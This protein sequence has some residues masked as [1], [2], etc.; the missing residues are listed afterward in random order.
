MSGCFNK[1]FGVFMCLC[2]L[3]REF[4]EFH[5]IYP[6]KENNVKWIED[7]VYM[8]PSKSEVMCFDALMCEVYCEMELYTLG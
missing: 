7:C 3:V 6:E 1:T 4:I 8:R 2:V 5:R